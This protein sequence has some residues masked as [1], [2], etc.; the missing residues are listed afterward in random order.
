MKKIIL[1]FDYEMFLGKSGTIRNCIIEPTNELLKVFDSK[2]IKGVFFVDI[3]FLLKL[4]DEGLVDEYNQIVENIHQILKQGSHIELHIHPHW[5]DAKYST[6]TGQWDLSNDQKYRM[7]ALS[8]DKRIEIFNSGVELLIKICRIIQPDYK[9]RSFRAGGLCI[10]PFDCFESLM[11]AHGIFVESSVAVGLASENGNQNFDFSRAKTTSPYRFS[12]NPIVPDNTG[13]F[14]EFP[15][16]TYRLSF[17]DKLIQKIKGNSASHI[18]YGD[19][20]SIRSMK[21]KDKAF[22]L[23]KFKS[24]NALVS[25]DGDFYEELLYTNIIKRKEKVITLLSHPK[26]LSKESIQLISK[27][28]ASTEIEFTTFYEE[29][30]RFLN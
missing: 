5:L 26:L 21:K 20:T 23:S 27:L 7:E 1:T 24:S 11:I 25:L 19:G 3:L 15:I 2:G 22:F 28:E 13:Q 17:F 4:S 30:N 9:V 18:I 29:S 6:G 16:L 10:Q 8:E 12:N 14:L